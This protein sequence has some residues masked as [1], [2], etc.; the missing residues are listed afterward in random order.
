MNTGRPV[1]HFCQRCNA[2]TVQ[3]NLDFLAL[4]IKFDTKKTAI[5]LFVLFLYGYQQNISVHISVPCEIFSEY[6]SE[7]LL[8]I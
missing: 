7:V 8:H 1:A 5:K 4:M 3:S 6:R 2:I